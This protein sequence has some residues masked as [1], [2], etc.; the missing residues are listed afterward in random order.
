M[1]YLINNNVKRCPVSVVIPTYNRKEMLVTTI[2][3]I[4]E[5]NPLPDEIIVHVDGNDLQSEQAI[6]N[7]FSDIKIL[8]SQVN[9]GPGGGRNLLIKSAQHEIVASFDDDSYPIDQDYFARLLH[10]FQNYPD[11]SVVAAATYTRKQPVGDDIKSTRWVASFEGCGCAYKR[12]DFLKT[13]GYMQLQWA[14]GA[15]EIDIAIQL[16]AQDGK[17][18]QTD[19]LRVYHDTCH[20]HHKN[21]DINAANISNLALLAYVR[22]PLTMWGRGILQVFNRVLYAVKVQRYAGIILGITSIPSNIWSYRQRRKPVSRAALEKYLNL[23]KQPLTV[24]WQVENF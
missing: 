12:T 5:C 19:W 10:I 15:E 2:Q 8:K 7:N 16:Y 13:D 23:R 4:L 6:K 17:I 20:Q 24:P 1:V 21:F 14:Y 11:A 18:L 3:K 9:I 22:Y